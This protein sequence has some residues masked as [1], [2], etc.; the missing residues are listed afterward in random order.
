MK[1]KEITED[2]VLDEAGFN[3]IIS[4]I[5]NGDY[6][7]ISAHV[8][9][10]P[11]NINFLGKKSYT[12]EDLKA[13][14]NSQ[15]NSLYKDLKNNGLS[16]YK[17]EGHYGGLPEKSFIVKRPDGMEPAKFE[18]L[19]IFLGQKYNQHS[20][21]IK[22]NDKTE[23]VHMSGERVPFSGTVSYGDVQGDHSVFK[24]RRKF[25]IEG[26]QK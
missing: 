12:E 9:S 24:G 10:I 19:I 7:G 15:N 20:V 21:L 14:N 4:A 25:K 6:A 23:L 2:K 3:K 17:V 22:T 1:I 16:F 11:P 18:E 13:Y 26:K 5:K 8:A